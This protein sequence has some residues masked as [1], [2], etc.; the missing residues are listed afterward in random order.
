MVR[1]FLLDKL[2]KIEQNNNLVFPGI[3]IIFCLMKLFFNI[4]QSVSQVFIAGI[5]NSSKNK[6]YKK[7]AGLTL[8]FLLISP[9]LTSYQIIKGDYSEK[10]QIFQDSMTSID[11][12]DNRSNK[13]L[14]Y[15]VKPGETITSIARKFSLKQETIMSANNLWSKNDLRI[16][17][18]IKVLSFDGLSHFIEKG[19]TIESI[20]KKYKVSQEDIMSA[21]QLTGGDRLEAGRTLVI[22]GAKRKVTVYEFKPK[23][24]N[25][26][27]YNGGKSVSGKLIWP[28]VGQITQGYRRGHAAIDIGNRN[29]GP[30]YAAAGGKVIKA[31]T[32]WNGGYGNVI[33]IDHGNGMQTLYAHNEKFY[34]TEGQYVEQ[35][36]TISWMGNTGRVYG[37]TGIHLHF[38]VRIKG[39]KYNPMNFLQFKK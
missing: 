23:P 17:D 7:V 13:T 4:L 38:E 19:E 2:N 8:A 39:I 36:Q 5:N 33:I 9:F 15:T 16:G 37:P 12:D 3:S 27:V 30:I 14:I 29:K 22:P 31:R 34:V 18:D 20:S 35:G 21:N 1:G 11:Q 10:E 24:I 26:N 6:L 25:I 32:G 28:A